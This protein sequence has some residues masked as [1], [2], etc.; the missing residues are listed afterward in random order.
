[1]HA[2]SCWH[3]RE[4]MLG[5]ACSSRP[6]PPEA[7]PKLPAPPRAALFATPVQP[8]A[9]RKQS[10]AQRLD[11]MLFR[12]TWH[13]G[14]R[15]QRPA[16]IQPR[17]IRQLD[18]CRPGAM[19]AML[20]GRAACWQ[21]QWGGRPVCVC[22]LLHLAAANASML[23]IV[24]HILAERAA[25]GENVALRAQ[26]V[27]AALATAHCDCSL[28]DVA[29]RCRGPSACGLLLHD[30]AIASSLLLLQALAER[31][32][33]RAAS[34]APATPHLPPAWLPT[35]APP[36]AP[37]AWR[38]P[39]LTW[40]QRPCQLPKRSCKLP[41]RAL[42][43]PGR[44]MPLQHDVTLQQDTHLARVPAPASSCQSGLCLF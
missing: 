43:K 16:A 15:R 29:A 44:P 33:A 26:I 25:P 27:R 1:M 20:A 9:L 14:R 31:G 2:C 32:A 21:Q 10:A 38:R 37:Q 17:C 42:N 6:E 5:H 12:R 34:A 18:C 30:A 22:C 28:E 35:A 24:R 39:R 7:G 41:A 19:R 23:L 11:W 8:A 13:V 36:R 4:G 3:Q 40:R